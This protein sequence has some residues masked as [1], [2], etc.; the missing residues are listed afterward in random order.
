[1]ATFFSLFP[2]LICKQV[3]IKNLVNSLFLILSLLLS[4]SFFFYSFIPFL[5][6]YICHFLNLNF[7]INTISFKSVSTEIFPPNPSLEIPYLN[8]FNESLN[9][10]YKD[11]STTTG[12]DK[13]SSLNANLLFIFPE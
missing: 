6:F 10:T 3:L 13:M 11:P 12:F 7:Q 2:F 1:M 5:S 4:F 8:A 9:N